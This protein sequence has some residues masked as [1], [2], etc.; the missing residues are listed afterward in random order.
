MK[1]PLRL[2]SGVYLGI[3]PFPRICNSK[4]ITQKKKKKL[5]ILRETYIADL[6]GK[7]L[8]LYQSSQ[9]V[10]RAANSAVREPK[11]TER[12]FLISLLSIINRKP[13]ENKKYKL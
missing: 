6:G 3:F 13:T 10:A 1:D 12:L 9:H 5:L 2:S 7:G 4:T 11:H 8:Q